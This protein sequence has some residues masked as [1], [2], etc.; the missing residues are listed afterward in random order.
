LYVS[1]TNRP[2]TDDI[3][4]LLAKA[5]AHFNELL[6]ARFSA[7]GYPEIRGSFGSVLVP[8]FEQDGRRIGELAQV[9]RLS[10]QSL[11]GLV[12]ACELAGLVERRRDAADG[13]AMVVRLTARGRRFQT[14]AEQ[15]LDDLDRDLRD[16]L[17]Q[18]KHDALRTALKG[19]MEL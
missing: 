8:L 1:R 11:T 4:F 19:V 5:S 12:A 3:G 10:K 16:A 14:V 9:A 17:G 7:A 15:I 2:P 13:R 18:R 6:L